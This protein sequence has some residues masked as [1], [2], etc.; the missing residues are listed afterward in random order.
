M[1]PHYPFVAQ[2]AG[3]RCEYCHAPA[4]VFNYRFD[5]EHITTAAHGGASHRANFALAC[6]SC[7]G[8]KYSHRTGQDP[9]TG[10]EEPLFNPRREVWEQHFR[11]DLGTGEITGL[12]ATGRATVARLRVLS[13]SDL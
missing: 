7:N 9:L 12:T 2:R 10:N 13:R 5:V 3:Y 8:F 4:I 6:R 1:N 11:I